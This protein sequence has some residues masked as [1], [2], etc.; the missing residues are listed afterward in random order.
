MIPHSFFNILLGKLS[1]LKIPLK[2]LIFSLSIQLVKSMFDN[3]LFINFIVLL[4]AM[5][6]RIEWA[7]FA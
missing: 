7:V 5:E 1:R 6:F 2:C 3:G 4:Q